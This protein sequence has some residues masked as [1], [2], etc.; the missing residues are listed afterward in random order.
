MNIEYYTAEEAMKVLKKARSTFFKEVD[1]GKIPSELEPGR[2]RGRRYPKN[3]IDILANRGERRKIK[4]KGPQHLVLAPSTIADLW[5]EVLIGLEMYGEDDV[6]PFETLLEWRD[7]ND[8]IFMHLKDQGQSV[9]YSSLMPIEEKVLQALIHDKIRENDIPLRA[10]KQ[11]TDP[12]ISVYVATVT[13]KPSGNKRIDRDRGGFLIKQTVKWALTLNRQF[14]IKNWY[15]IGATKEG[16]KLFE[17]LGFE[18]IVSLY[19]GERKGYLV[20]D[21]KQPVKLINEVLADMKREKSDKKT[22]Q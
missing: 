19:D 15:G 1:D 7:I 10:I 13:V 16:Q 14:D 9:G 3:A 12:G 4:G 22:E 18:E 6:P 21:I 17:R 20:Q 8:E 2:Q 5:T 11:W